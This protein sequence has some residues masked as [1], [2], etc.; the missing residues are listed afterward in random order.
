MTETISS[1]RSNCKNCRR[2]DTNVVRLIARSAVQGIR[3][4]LHIHENEDL[5]C[6]LTRL[7]ALYPNEWKPKTMYHFYVDNG[8]IYYHIESA[9][10]LRDQDHI[11][12][13]TIDDV[14]DIP[15]IDLNAVH[16]KLRNEIRLQPHQEQGI[17]SI[18]KMEQTARGGILA[19]E[20]GLG[21]T[22]QILTTII[23]QQPKLDIQA[24]TL[25]V[26]PS[27]G[28]G[29][30]WTEEIRTKI[31]VWQFTVFYISRGDDLSTR[32]TMLQGGHHYLRTEFD[33]NICENTSNNLPAPLFDTKWYRIVLDECN[34][35]RNERTKLADAIIKLS[36][37]FRWCLTGTPLQNDVSELH[38]IF[39]FLRVDL[40]V[41]KRHNVEYITGLLRKHMIRR[42]KKQLQNVLALKPKKE[43]RVVLEFSPPER[44]LYDYLETILYKQLKD[45]RNIP[46]L[47]EDGLGSSLLYLRLKQVCGHHLLLLEKFPDLIPTSQNQSTEEVVNILNSK[48]TIQWRGADRRDADN[49][50]RQV[51]G[52][53]K[54]FYDQCDETQIAQPN[55]QELEKLPFINRSTKVS[56]LVKFLTEQLEKAPNEKIVVVSQFVDLLAMVSDALKDIHIEHENYM[57]DMA[58]YQ[59]KNSLEKF[60]FGPMC[61]VL[62]LSLK[63]GGVGLN[64]QCA[65][66]MV[67]LD[68]WWNPATMEQAIA[69]IHRMNQTKDT[70]IYTVIIKDTIEEGLLDDVL[71]KKNELFATVVDGN[72]PMDFSTSEQLLDEKS[73]DNCDFGA[74]DDDNDDGDDIDAHANGDTENDGV[75]FMN[76]NDTYNISDDEFDN[77][78]TIGSDMLDF[79]EHPSPS[80]NTYLSPTPSSDL[81]RKRL[82]IN[83][84]YQ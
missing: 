38:P 13:T 5:A 53:I 22:L 37:T 66:H 42:K 58:N 71:K 12:V 52:I 68:R 33:L 11:L 56:W 44:A 79:L 74:S 69:R 47:Q 35:M 18:I 61:Q 10:W 54:D 8:G 21:K 14:S 36:A 82:K 57:G 26:V 2:G 45:D 64:L 20:M 65:N 3:Y 75:T 84:H 7:C 17:Q 43:I 60:N 83:A 80:R 32:T 15:D 29:H 48:S 27:H 70:Y 4:W 31:D 41:A 50:L 81:P 46:G 55:M 9:F 72:Q 76:Q 25:I 28:V 49:E 40:P 59:R 63:A 34:K 77:M 1:G 62:L 19:D 73:I 39:K 30:Q 24:R 67:L 78:S 51:C 16:A 6:V 23:R